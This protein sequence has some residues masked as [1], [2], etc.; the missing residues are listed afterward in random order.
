[1]KS[2]A[3]F[4]AESVPPGLEKWCQDN[5]AAFKKAHGDQWEAFLLST[6]W[7]MYKRAYA[8]PATDS[9]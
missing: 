9:Q 5:E 3:E 2:L 8:S 6:A 1:M 4:L 7:T